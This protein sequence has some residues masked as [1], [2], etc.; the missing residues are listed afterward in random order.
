MTDVLT[1]N[2]MDPLFN[3]CLDFLYD[4]HHTMFNVHLEPALTNEV[5]CV[6]L[7]PHDPQSMPPPPFPVQALSGDV[8]AARSDSR[9]TSVCIGYANLCGGARTCK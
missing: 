2:Q 6:Y 8:A 5:R 3:C 7:S 4:L 1:V 9:Y